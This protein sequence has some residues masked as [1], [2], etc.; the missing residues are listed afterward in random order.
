MRLR[1]ELGRQV[2][3]EERVDLVSQLTR[4]LADVEVDR[5]IARLRQT[6]ALA[7]IKAAPGLLEKA[8]GVAEHERPG[9][10][11]Q[12]VKM[13]VVVGGQAVAAEGVQRLRDGAACAIGV[14]PRRQRNLRARVGGVVG[15]VADRLPGEIFAAVD[16]ADEIGQGMRDALI[17]SDGL[18]EG[19]ALPG[20]RCGQPDGLVRKTRKRRGHEQLPLLEGLRESLEP[21]RLARQRAAA[22]LR[23]RRSSA[24][25]VEA[26]FGSL[27]RAPSGTAIST[28]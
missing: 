3:P 1:L 25:G 10:G 2:L 4:L 16:I 5:H 28:M 23:S 24:M 21:S 18:P 12:I 26:R 6:G 19:H 20:V 27:L 9:L 17:G 14:P 7:G 8:R 11:A 13:D 22:A 15:D